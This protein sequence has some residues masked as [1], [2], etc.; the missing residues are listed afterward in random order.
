MEKDHKPDKPLCQWCRIRVRFSILLQP[1]IHDRPYLFLPE[2]VY[3]QKQSKMQEWGGPQEYRQP[4]KT[5]TMRT[6]LPRKENQ[7]RLE[8][9]EIMRK[10]SLKCALIAAVPALTIA[11]VLYGLAMPSAAPAAGEGAELFV[12]KGCSKCHL[13][14]STRRRVGPG[15]KGLF[16]M[17]K[18]P[19][20]GRSVTEENV[21]KQLKTPFGS[22]PS[23]ADRLTEEETD[24][25]IAYLKTL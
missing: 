22:M 10:S 23:Y 7:K 6:P 12:S 13:T 5:L 25:L 11:L 9:V 16:K 4:V 20:S 18:L 8:G 3:S 2:K 17:E 1:K 15:L 14:D 21:R 19:A 24:Q